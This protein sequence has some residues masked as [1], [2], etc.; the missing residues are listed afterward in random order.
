[1]GVKKLGIG[2]LRL[3]FLIG[4]FLLKQVIQ[5]M[6]LHL[7]TDRECDLVLWWIK[8]LDW[9]EHTGMCFNYHSTNTCGYMYI[10][11]SYVCPYL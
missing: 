2:N 3:K 4:T 6:K 5:T 9:F 8:Y 1:M 10:W 7:K 11:I